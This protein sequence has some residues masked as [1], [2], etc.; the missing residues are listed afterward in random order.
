MGNSANIQN[1][2]INTG[3]MGTLCMASVINTVCTGTLCTASVKLH[4]AFRG[5]IRLTRNGGVKPPGA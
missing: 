5:S 1:E 4:R 2:N 3:C